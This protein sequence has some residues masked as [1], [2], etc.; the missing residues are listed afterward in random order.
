MSPWLRNVVTKNPLSLLGISVIITKNASI[1]SQYIDDNSLPQPSTS[2]DGPS[3]V[4]PSDS[5]EDIQRARQGL[6]AASLEMLQ[7]AVGPSEFLP[8]LATGVRSESSDIR[9]RLMTEVSIYLL[10][11]MAL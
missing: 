11:N 10:P 5:P 4:L 6:I 3:T 7:L 2:S 8:N 1:V 9:Q